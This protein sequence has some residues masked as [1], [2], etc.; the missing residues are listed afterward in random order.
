MPKALIVYHTQTG[1]TEKLAKAVK[2]G[3][4]AGGVEVALK[5]ASEAGLDDLLSADGYCF[6]DTGLFQLY[7]WRIKGFL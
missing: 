6:R 5:K 1:N 4:E 3:L 7:G 2:E